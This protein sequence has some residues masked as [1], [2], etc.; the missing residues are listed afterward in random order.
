MKAGGANP[1]A[2]VSRGMLLA[3]IGTLIL[4]ALSY[5]VRQWRESRSTVAPPVEVA[6]ANASPSPAAVPPAVSQAAP[7]A[8]PASA[9]PAN[10]ATPADPAN[11]AGAT[12]PPAPP[13]GAPGA[14]PGANSAPAAPPPPGLRPAMPGATS[15][16]MASH[17]PPA[18]PTQ[19]ANEPAP[20]PPPPPPPPPTFRLIGRYVESPNPVVLFAHENGVIA[21][22]P[23]SQLPGGFTLK[24]IRADGVTV[25]RQSNKEKIEMNLETPK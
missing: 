8:T 10:A 6:V 1:G 7:E 19:A 14:A 20:P 9:P 23:G 4:V 13:A 2:G 21:A 22:K 12:P 11:P 17:K 16:A 5:G 24:A 3:L 15:D 18:P 25:M